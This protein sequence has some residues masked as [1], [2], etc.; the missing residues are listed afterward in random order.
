MGQSDLN[1]V[2]VLVRVVQEGSF[3]SAARV[4]G[5]PKT[6]VS[7]KVAELEEQLGVQLLQRDDAQVVIVLERLGHRS[8][9]NAGRV[10]W[11]GAAIVATSGVT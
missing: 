2:L 4:L 10:R 9:K 1:A 6:T 7:R 3:R 8:R 11:R 5:M